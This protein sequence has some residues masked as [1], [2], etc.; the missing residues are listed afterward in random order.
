MIQAQFSGNQ[1]DIILDS[2]KAV[3]DLQRMLP[4]T[5]ELN[6]YGGNEFS[7]TLPKKLTDK[8]VEK[9]SFVKKNHIYYWDP[10][11]SFALVYKDSN[12]S[13]YKLVHIGEATGNLAGILDS[14]TDK[15]T[16][17]LTSKQ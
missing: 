1:Y 15:A 2:N 6:R 16:I 10:W 7:C 14:T 8:G 11:T 4:L 3:S 12:I 9:T 5:L 17:T 13:P